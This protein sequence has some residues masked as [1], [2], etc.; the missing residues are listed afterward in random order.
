MNSYKLLFFSTLL[1]GSMVSLSANSWIGVWMGLEINLLSMIPLMKSK[2]NMMSTEAA[3]KYFITQALASTLLLLTAILMMKIINKTISLN[4]M[5]QLSM[6]M[7]MGSAPFHFWFPEVIN[8]MT[9]MNSLII[10]TWQKIAPMMIIMYTNM[11]NNFIYTIIIWNSLIS[12]ILG[13]NQTSLRKIMAYS[14]MN[15][16]AWM[17]ASMMIS[18]TMW[19]FYFTI[20]CLI[21]INIIVSFILMN[22]FT[23]SQTMTSNMNKMNKIMLMINFMS[24]GGLPP[25]LGFFPKWLVIQALTNSNNLLINVVLICLT[26]IPLYYYTRIMMASLIMNNQTSF[27]SLKIKINNFMLIMMNLLTLMGLI[28]SSSLYIYL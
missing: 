18:E 21:S 15:H 13:L 17:L 2:T 24:L 3:I 25:F 23:L 8:G 5:I 14:S 22:S 27:I 12:A 11:S 7:K 19:K 9:W 20:Y 16:I 10:L 4:Y 28:M 1:T 6:L 26:M